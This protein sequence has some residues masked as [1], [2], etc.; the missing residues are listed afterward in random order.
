MQEGPPVM[1]GRFAPSP[2]GRMHLGNVMSALLSY[3]SAKS[4]GG[5]WLLRIEDLDPQRCS[6]D[7][8]RR[9]EEDLVTLGMEWDEGGVDEGCCQ[10]LR[11]DI[12]REALDHLDVYPCYCSR[13][14][15]LS[16]S[17]PHES[18]GRVIYKGTCR[19]LLPS[20]RPDGPCS[21]RVRVP[22]LEVSFVDGHYGR[23]CI[24]L[25]RD[26]GD[27]IVRRRDGVAAYQLAVTVDDLLMGVTE[28]V[29][30]RDLL[31]STPQQ[32]FLRDCLSPWHCPAAPIRYCHIPL[33]CAPDGRRLSK[34]DAA[35]DLGQLLRHYPPRG[36]IGLTAFLCGI[37]PSP[38]PCSPSELV[39]LFDM[40]RVPHE[41]ISVDF[42]SS[43]EEK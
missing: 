25:A 36:I 30:G 40:S 19:D 22:D 11:S 31:L 34:R 26:C 33:L 7:Y 28:V 13:A 21:L 38:E 15:L 42:A 8:A 32:L 10:S 12:Y 23:Q 37:I 1:K 5:S 20:Q 9:L 3:L 27:F 39:P 43:I 4:Q 29:R 6:L 17:A 35:L 2:T 24:N 18:D 14:D 41:D 16:S